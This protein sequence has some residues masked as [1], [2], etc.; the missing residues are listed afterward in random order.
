MGLRATSVVSVRR[1]AAPGA[2]CGHGPRALKAPPLLRCP[3][4]Q[5]LVLRKTH[6]IS[7]GA[8]EL[9]LVADAELSQDRV[10]G[11]QLETPPAGA[12]AN[13]RGFEVVAPIRRDER[14]RSEASDDRLLRAGPMKPLEELLIHETRRED[15][16]PACQRS[17]EGAH[18]G[19]VGGSVPA[20]RERPDARVDEETQSRERS[21][22]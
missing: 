9:K 21:R 4:L 3:A 15:E 2:V 13:L 8:E 7:V 12:V 14:E 17:F 18:L 11:S 19:A 1:T 6:K 22:L 10:D 16:H 20:K 5:W